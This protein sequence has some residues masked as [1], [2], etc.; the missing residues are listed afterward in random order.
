LYRPRFLGH[1]REGIHA[2]RS[3]RASKSRRAA[4]ETWYADTLGFRRVPALAH[5]ADEGGPLMVSDAAENVK[6]ALFEGKLE[7]N[8]STV[9]PSPHA[10][11][12]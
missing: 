12:R 2:A 9:R 1:R 7:T 5:W 3:C 4:A 8:R 10:M 11:P 6:L